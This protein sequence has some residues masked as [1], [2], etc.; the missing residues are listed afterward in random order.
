MKYDDFN[1]NVKEKKKTIFADFHF[2]WTTNFWNRLTKNDSKEG[3]E[4]VQLTIRSVLKVCAND[5]C[6]TFCNGKPVV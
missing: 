1:W 6:V 2:H 5:V 3:N 4:E